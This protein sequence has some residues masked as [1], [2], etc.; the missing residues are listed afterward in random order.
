[1]THPPVLA[2]DLTAKARIRN[3]ALDLYAR[4]GEDKVSLRA[5]AAQAGVTLGLVQHHFKSKA[6]LL[7]AVDKL[8]VDHFARTIAEVPTDGSPAEIATARDEAVRRMLAQNPTVVDYLRR[9][10]LDPAGPR[11]HLVDGLV[12]LTRREV[13]G[14]RWAGLASTDARE[15]TQV[16][17]VLAR[18]VG[19]LFLTPMVDA[20]WGR[21]AGP[22]DRRPRLRVVI[23]D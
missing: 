4:Q 3:A 16:L 5:I 11:P 2:E 18:Q 13:A 21:V 10:V 12:E 15:S 22:D 19:E 6:N 8:V 17:V 20:I 9:A 23:E 14:L 1:M 7:D